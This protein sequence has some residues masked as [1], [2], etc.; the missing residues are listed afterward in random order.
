MRGIS[1]TKASHIMRSVLDVARKSRLP[2]LSIVILDS[3]GHIK[4]SASEDGVG[5]LR[6]EIAQSKAYACLGMSME[7]RDLYQLNQKGVLSNAFVNAVCAAS[8]GRF[9]T[10]PGGAL[11]YQDDEIIGAIGV[12]GASAE[13]DEQLV[14]SGLKSV[15]E[16]EPL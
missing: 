9:N 4:C 3:G 10:N 6:H 13:Q 12:S 5:I 7:T 11:L 2:P 14:R 15:I 8:N 16:L 1:Y